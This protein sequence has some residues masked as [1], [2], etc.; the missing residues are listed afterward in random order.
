[1]F[2]YWLVIFDRR[3]GLPTLS[4]RT[5]TENVIS[6]AGREIIVIRG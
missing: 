4:D 6:A 1:M 3:S 2:R 5:M